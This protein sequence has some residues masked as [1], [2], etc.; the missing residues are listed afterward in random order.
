VRP[1]Y[2]A[3]KDLG[4]GTG[5]RAV[6]NKSG[7][8]VNR[9][10]AREGEKILVV[11]DDA[12]V[13]DLLQVTLS[14]RGFSVVT[15][16]N[17]DEAVRR[18]GLARPDLVV[19]DVDLPRRSGI[20]I[21]E[22]IRGQASFESLPIILISSNS[23]SEAKLQGLRSGADDYIAKPFSPRELIL[24]IRRILDRVEEA[25][26]LTRKVRSLEGQVARGE[27]ALEESRASMR[28][29][30]FRV[31]SVLTALQEVG[32]ARHP[33]D[34]F[35]R[36]V[37]IAVGHLDLGVT[38]L[39]LLDE[40][41]DVFECKAGRGCA[42]SRQTELTFRRGGALAGVLAAAQRSLSL[43]SAE[44]VPEASAEVLRLRATGIDYLHP[45][46]VEGALRGAIG[47]SHS[48]EAPAG[49]SES[50][51][52]AAVARSV[53]VALVNQQAMAAMQ[54]SFLETSSLLIRSLEERHCGLAGHSD[55][56]ARTAHA[57][58]KHAGLSER[59]SE[60]VRLGAQLHD[61]GLV[62]IYEDLD[63]ADAALDED[64][65][66]QL[67]EAPVRAALTISEA[68]PLEAV[69]GIVRHHH[70]HWDGTGYPD[71]LGGES[72]PIGARIVAIANAFDALTHERP[73]RP[74]L[75]VR[76][77]LD[78]IA[79]EAGREFDPELV[80]EFLSN[81]GSGEVLVA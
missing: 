37:S 40:E 55:R 16:S 12:R 81:I 8:Q 66:R 43:V 42:M 31:G 52:I 20:E 78:L 3:T 32:Q 17:G 69:A 60:I 30:L 1:I 74:A 49:S 46:R 9:M 6:S 7:A 62:E 45:I 48:T 75:S 63:R 15:A 53:E 21:L 54:R 11:D 56:V 26:D 76:E 44:S 24:R 29:R 47:Y 59:E 80:Q 33:D 50:E 70:E 27:K 67:A 23:S 13:L 34:L 58:A 71:G 39:L 72:I 14:G 64:A 61:L 2:L 73:H 36:F 77:A 5:G 68:G 57:L 35:A 65:R 25:T 22:E 19:L 18:V 38:S 51:L 41:R 4:F 79:S 28:R 10:T